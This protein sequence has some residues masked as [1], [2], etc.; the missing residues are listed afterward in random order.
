MVDVRKL[1]LVSPRTLEEDTTAKLTKDA[2]LALVGND[3]LVRKKIMQ[4][5]FCY[6]CC[7]TLI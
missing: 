7:F 1:Y 4:I 2:I 5:C 3:C 6:T